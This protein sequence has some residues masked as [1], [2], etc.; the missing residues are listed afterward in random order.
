MSNSIYTIGHSNLQVADFLRLLDM[1]SIAAI[2]DVR[3]SPFSRMFPHFNREPL[4]AVLKQAGIKYV[5]MGDSLGG[6]P[7][8]PTCFK[9]RQVQY[10]RVARLPAFAD[11]LNRLIRGAEKYRITLMCSEKDPITCHRMLLVARQLSTFGIDVQHILADGKLES[12]EEAENRM[13][14]ATGVPREDLFDPR[15][16]LIDRAYSRQ[17]QAFAFTLHEE[18]ASATA[19]G[20]AS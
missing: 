17:S 15:S 12:Q 20:I 8:D 11:E 13:M 18:E 5:F 19:Q 7:E 4:R 1:H 9:L 14:D 2:A 10:D 6:R 3:S 16:S